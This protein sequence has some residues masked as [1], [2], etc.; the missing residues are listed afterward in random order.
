MEE[1]KL[2]NND[3]IL[4]GNLGT[5]KIGNKVRDIKSAFHANDGTV[6]ITIGETKP[7]PLIIA[8]KQIAGLSIYYPEKQIEI[9]NTDQ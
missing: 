5:I 7:E 6:T 4:P 2:Q 1:N 8:G 3:F 9:K